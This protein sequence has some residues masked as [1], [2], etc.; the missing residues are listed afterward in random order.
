MP[1]IVIEDLTEEEKKKADIAKAK[2]DVNTWK[3]FFMVMIE[4][5][6]EK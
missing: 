5:R 6:N 3:K 4:E 2:S 1:S